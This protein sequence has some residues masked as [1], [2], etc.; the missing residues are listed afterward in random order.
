MD[1]M[2]LLLAVPSAAIVALVVMVGSSVARETREH[3]APEFDFDMRLFPNWVL[4]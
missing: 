3:D 2:T 4:A 1:A